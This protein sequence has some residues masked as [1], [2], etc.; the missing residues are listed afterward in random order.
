MYGDKNV[1]GA[2]TNLKHLL[3]GMALFPKQMSSVGDLAVLVRGEWGV[4]PRSRTERA[5]IFL[6]FYS[7]W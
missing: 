3:I 4:A 5:L 2:V 7:T 6:V 1:K